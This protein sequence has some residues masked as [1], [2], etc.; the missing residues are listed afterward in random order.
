M[1]ATWALITVASGINENKN[2]RKQVGI[3]AYPAAAICSIQT[4]LAQ[5]HMYTAAPDFK[6]LCRLQ[7]F[8][9][10]VHICFF[11]VSFREFKIY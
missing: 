10:Q 6:P 1:R 2:W 9:T 11:M 7:G 8:N 3:S 4:G 5:T